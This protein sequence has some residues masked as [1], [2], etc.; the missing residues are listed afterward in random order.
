M[1]SSRMR[2]ISGVVKTPEG[3]PGG[4]ANEGCA[5]VPEVPFNASRNRKKAR[6]QDISIEAESVNSFTCQF[7][8]KSLA[9][10]KMQHLPHES[11]HSASDGRK[12]Y[13]HLSRVRAAS[14]EALAA[15]T[16]RARYLNDLPHG[17]CHPL[18]KV[19][20]E[21]ERVLQARLACSG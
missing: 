16:S 11:R 8:K 18:A 5:L 3:I 13:G 10:Q 4:W 2:H 19:E 20:P 9:D 15:L 12:L 1:A 7:P 17:N 14:L 21:L 6:S